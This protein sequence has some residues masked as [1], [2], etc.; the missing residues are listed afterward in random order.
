MPGHDGPGAMC[1]LLGLRDKGRPAFL[2][3]LASDGGEFGKRSGLVE[4]GPIGRPFG[5][6][7]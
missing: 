4:D 3:A 6:P 7:S 1:D 2:M 5:R